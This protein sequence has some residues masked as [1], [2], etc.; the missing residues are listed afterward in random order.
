[1]KKLRLIIPVVFAAVCVPTMA[2]AK[3]DTNKLLAGIKADIEAQRL[4]TP[5]GNN[6][7]EKIDAYRLQNP[8]D[9]KVV[10]LVYEWG[11]AYVELANKAIDAKNYSQAADYLNKVWPVAYL[12]P[13][14]EQTQAKL[15]GL[16]KPGAAAAQAASAQELARQKQLAEAAAREKERAEAERQKRIAEEKRQAELA[17]KKAEEER[18]RRQEEERLR[19]IAAAQAAEA[20]KKEEAQKAATQEKP[21][22]QPKPVAKPVAKA[23]VPVPAPV[24][25]A[26]AVTAPVV[27]A[28]SLETNEVTALWEEAEE[29]SEAIATYPLSAE[30]IRQRDRGIATTLQPICKAIVEN[31]ASVVVHTENKSDYRWLTVRLTLCLRQTDSNFR[32][33]HSYQGDLAD[34]EPYISL[35]PSRDVSI[36]RQAVDEN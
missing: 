31:D 5:A 18:A 2:V 29:T 9:F 34:N 27:A 19:R 26:P 3:Q 24:V 36:L 7:L 11:E 33:R 8:H 28:V 20:A 6:A 15:D 32:L 4:S 25:S 13:G 23:P 14:L 12:T 35:H 1:M 17:K 30:K 21:K 22:A 10:P 16:Y